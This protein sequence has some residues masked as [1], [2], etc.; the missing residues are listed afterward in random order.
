MVTGRQDGDYLFNYRV[1][2]KGIDSMVTG[3]LDG[4][5]LLKFYV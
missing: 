3:R 1:K 4:V 5:G 2:H